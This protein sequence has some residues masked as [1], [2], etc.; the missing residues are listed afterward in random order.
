[1]EQ[2][3]EGGRYERQEDGTL[4]RMEETTSNPVLS[5]I[6]EFTRDVSAEEVAKPKSKRN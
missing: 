5:K 2:A 6:T 3:K 4:K 1:M